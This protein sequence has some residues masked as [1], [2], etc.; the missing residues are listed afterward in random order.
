MLSAGENGGK[1][2]AFHV[3]VPSL[4]GS[5]S[6]LYMSNCQTGAAST[7]KHENS[8]SLRVSKKPGSAVTCPQYT[9]LS[10]PVHLTS[11]A[12]AGYGFSSSPT[13]RG[14]G[15][16]EIAKTFNELMLKLGY[17]TYVAQG[18]HMSLPALIF[19]GALHALY[20]RIGP[21]ASPQCCAAPLHQPSMSC[22]HPSLH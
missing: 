2:Q 5:P 11:S 14:F 12:H 20:T 8:E 7:S 4:P 6:S 1:K 13:Q 10:A 19:T 16:S 18:R 15:V 17:D 9:Q 3:V 21:S 22:S